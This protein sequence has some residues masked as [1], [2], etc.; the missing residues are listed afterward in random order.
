MTKGR[1]QTTTTM[2]MMKIAA[3]F[4]FEENSSTFNVIN[5]SRQILS[6]TEI[7]KA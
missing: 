3:W 5:N 7:E 6:Q 2:M 4:I 1:R